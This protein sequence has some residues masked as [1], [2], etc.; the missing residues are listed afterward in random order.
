MLALRVI[1]SAINTRVQA[2]VA[3]YELVPPGEEDDFNAPGGVDSP[4]DSDLEAED[5]L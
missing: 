2:I 4:A 5:F 1:T 3:R